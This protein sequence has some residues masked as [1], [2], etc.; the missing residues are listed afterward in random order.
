MRVGHRLMLAVLPSLIGVLLV[1][2]LA[3][4]G[5]YQH[6]FPHLLLVIAAIAVILSL[7]ISWRNTRYVAA[8]VERLATPVAPDGQVPRRGDELDAIAN[9]VDRLTTAVTTARE[10]GDRREALA[11]S[12]AGDYRIILE[13]VTGSIAAQL[14]Q[15]QLPLHVLLASR[16][17]DL[18][19]NQEEMIEAARRAADEADAGVRRVRRVLE[20]DRGGGTPGTREPVHPAE[21]VTAAQTIAASHAELRRITLTVAVPQELPR[22][23]GDR[24]RLEEA[25]SAILCAAVD[26]SSDGGTVSVTGSESGDTVILD[27]RHSG[28][29]T[30][31]L[32]TI[33]ATRLV[34]SQDGA[35][36]EEAGSIRVTLPAER[37][38]SATA[39]LR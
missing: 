23:V 9:T 12:R 24:Y 37:L 34:G 35:V 36:R 5:Q 21:L 3:Y 8:R 30:P 4:W 15:V 29:S 33:L 14:E 26:R 27:V 20:I 11:E 38:R 19:E 1:A 7:V 22:I 32:D 18:N 28:A 13:T 25:L 39:P 6:Q 17:G 10:E 31:S 2:A 16:F